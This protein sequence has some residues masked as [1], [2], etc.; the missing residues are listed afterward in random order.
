M[1]FEAHLSFGGCFS[2]S[3]W[4]FFILHFSHPCVLSPPPPHAEF[5]ELCPSLRALWEL[6]SHT[7]CLPMGMGWD[8]TEL[9]TKDLYKPAFFWEESPGGGQGWW[10]DSSCVSS[11]AGIEAWHHTAPGATPPPWKGAGPMHDALGDG[12]R[13]TSLGSLRSH[14]W[15]TRSSGPSSQGNLTPLKPHIQV[16]A[17]APPAS[18][19][20]M[21]DS[22][23]SWQR[24]P[25][26]E[27]Q[28]PP[29]PPP[30]PPRLS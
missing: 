7:Q 11:L 8:Y 20:L 21:E 29:P 10:A 28:M 19:G 23:S 13:G 9:G 18:L 26:P 16:T 4:L 22:W 27:S 3:C 24:L 15:S 17:K 6:W 14:S 30:P 12:G 5:L 1:A 2:P 25:A